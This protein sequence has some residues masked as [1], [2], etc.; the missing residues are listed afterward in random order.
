MTTAIENVWF[1]PLIARWRCEETKSEEISLCN[2]LNDVEPI[3]EKLCARDVEALYFGRNSF[4][5]RLKAVASNE[6]G[7][8]PLWSLM[9][10]DLPCFWGHSVSLSKIIFQY[11]FPRL[12]PPTE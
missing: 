1:K 8:V 11:A 6:S 9:Q 5:V 4:V 10:Q 7:A 2:F 3:E 12:D